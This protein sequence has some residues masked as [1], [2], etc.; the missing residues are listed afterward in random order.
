G[1]RFVDVFL[2]QVVHALLAAALAGAADAVGAIHRQVDLVAVGR[3]QHGLAAV[4]VDEAGDAVFEIECDVV[5]HV[6]S[7][8]RSQVIDVDHLVDVVVVQN[9]LLVGDHRLFASDIQRVE[10]GEIGRASC[11]E[12]VQAAGR[13][14]STG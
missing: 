2:T 1:Q 4:A 13:G 14:G 11:R 9:D 12:R 7:P 3:I 5:A 8:A 6:G 10:G